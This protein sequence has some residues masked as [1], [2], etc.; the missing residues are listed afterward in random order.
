LTVGFLALILRSMK[1]SATPGLGQLEAAVMDRL[2]TD[3][4]A[5]VKAVH[6]VIGESRGIALNTVQSTMERLYRKGLLSRYKLSH[7]FVYEPACS[8]EEFGAR[9]VGAVVRQLA[10]DEPRTMLN[11]FVDVAEQGGDDVLAELEQLVAERRS[12]GKG[13][14]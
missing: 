14:R 9:V 5:D 1:R 13:V 8:R 10:R 3:G 4:A 7:A 6:R 12:K 11:A 2:W